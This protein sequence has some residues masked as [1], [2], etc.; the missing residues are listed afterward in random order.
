M[1]IMKKMIR[2]AFTLFLILM[3]LGVSTISSKAYGGNTGDIID[4]STF[5]SDYSITSIHI[6][7]D[8]FEITSTAF[9]NLY[10]L[11]S[12]TV[13]SNN[14]IYASYSGCL[15]D[16]ALTELLC[17]PPA[18]SGAYIPDSVVSIGE[19]AL[20]GVPEDL[21]DVIRDVVKSHASEEGLDWDI[22]GDH[23][24]HVDGTIK[25]KQADGSVIFPNSELMGMAAAVVNEST[26][27]NMKRSK[28]LESCFNYVAEILSYERRM[29][30][31]T[32]NWT[33]AYAENALSTGKANC[34]GYAAAFAYIADGLGYDARVC[35]G[36]VA[37]S[38]GGQT[39]HAWTEV[40]VGNKGY[41][42]DTEMQDSKGSGYY[43]QT[44][45]SY[46]AKPIYKTTS[47]DVSF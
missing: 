40:R 19:Y 32:G 5:K 17:F 46:P 30:V 37:S 26:T 29:E 15:Y 22:P 33:A 13:S 36:T 23:F 41:I 24:V 18:L 39:A 12:I 45:N 25:W 14:P 1:I 44:Y 11:R 3:L 38:L 28:Q 2:K 7:S 20:H 31:P 4:S 47:Y 42:F 8:V 43:K 27:L 10:N 34:Y 6:G 16:K 21:K 9:R 35:V